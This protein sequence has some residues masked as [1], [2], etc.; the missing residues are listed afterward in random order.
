MGWLLKIPR[1]TQRR[2]QPLNAIH[3]ILGKTVENIGKSLVR[4]RIRNPQLERG[5]LSVDTVN[6]QKEPHLDERGDS[7]LCVIGGGQGG[8]GS[9]QISGNAQLCKVL[10]T[11]LAERINAPNLSV[12]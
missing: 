5:I 7:E 11:F 6:Q 1:L 2:I 10:G 9:S 12:T 8:A 3:L 4:S